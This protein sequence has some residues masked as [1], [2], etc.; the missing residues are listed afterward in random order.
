MRIIN[1]LRE[2]YVDHAKKTGLG[3]VVIENVNYI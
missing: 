3:I 1:Q 2:R